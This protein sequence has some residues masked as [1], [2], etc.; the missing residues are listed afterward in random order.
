MQLQQWS[1][2]ACCQPAG[3]ISNT[4]RSQHLLL[5][6]HLGA[7]NSVRP[8]AVTQV[9]CLLTWVVFSTK[10]WT[11]L[12][13]MLIFILCLTAL[14]VVVAAVWDLFLAFY[15]WQLEVLLQQLPS[16]WLDLAAS[17]VK[18]KKNSVQT[19]CHCISLSFYIFVFR[20]NA[21][22]RVLKLSAGFQ[23]SL[24]FIVGGLVIIKVLHLTW[25]LSTQYLKLRWFFDEKRQSYSLFGQTYNR[26]F[27][28][29]CKNS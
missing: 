22:M 5:C 6:C 17:C 8:Q 2:T 21:W 23:H 12:I 18:K 3:G 25:C 28:I 26:L 4:I 16:C 9:L 1:L 13:R 14:Y 10:T 24:F 20:S 29:S 11:C 7:N 15:S 27:K 19:E